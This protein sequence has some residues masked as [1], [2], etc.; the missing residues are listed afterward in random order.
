MSLS[1]DERAQGNAL[2]DQVKPGEVEFQGKDPKD[3]KDSK[4]P[5]DEDLP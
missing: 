4:D 5:K 1:S 2:G 3:K